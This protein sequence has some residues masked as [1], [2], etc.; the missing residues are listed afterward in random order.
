MT[1]QGRVLEALGDLWIRPCYLHERIPEPRP[2]I[3]QV[4]RAL[5][6]LH[7][8]GRVERL[9]PGEAYRQVPHEEG[10]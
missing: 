2:T 5:R 8:S 6:R 1:I 7:A 3:Q 4:K 10:A 9:D